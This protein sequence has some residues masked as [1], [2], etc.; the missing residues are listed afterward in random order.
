[1]ENIELAMVKM[2]GFG[3]VLS[4]SDPYPT[5]ANLLLVIGTCFSCNDLSIIVGNSFRLSVYILLLHVFFCSTTKT[6]S[7]EVCFGIGD[8]PCLMVVDSPVWNLTA[9]S[10]MKFNVFYC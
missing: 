2:C 7:A 9:L 4:L 1:M 5:T 10:K 6:T 8:E 3:P